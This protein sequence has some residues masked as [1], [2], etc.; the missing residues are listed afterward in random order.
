[1]TAGRKDRR[2][3]GWSVVALSLAGPVAVVALL[4]TAFKPMP[5]LVQREI[6]WVLLWGLAL[7]VLALSVRG[8]GR[9]LKMAG[10]GRFTGWSLVWGVIAGATAVLSF[11]LCSALLKL[12][13]VHSQIAA[14]PAMAL[15]GMPLW[16]RLA[17]LAT[18]GVCEEVLYRGYPIRRLGELTGSRVVGAVLPGLVF[19]AVH[20]PTWGLAH[21]V[22]VS[23]VTVIMTALFLWRGDL[24]SNIIAHLVT[25]AMPLLVMPLMLAH[26]P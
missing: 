13:G 8:E 4:H 25:D 12:A 7:A 1:M 2:A 9:P 23:A 17:S 15:V 10:I 14:A 26:H 11:P 16:A 24:W 20:A 5:F 3:L 21:L 6:S 19:V 18:A 22:F